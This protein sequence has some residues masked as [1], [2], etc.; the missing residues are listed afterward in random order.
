M[1]KK[2][3][4]VLIILIGVALLVYPW[5]A[6]YLNEHAAKSTIS[7]YENEVKHTEKKKGKRCW[8]KQE[9]IMKN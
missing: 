9:N 6:N 4:Q 7:T 8:K 5:I 3:I 1:K 2:I